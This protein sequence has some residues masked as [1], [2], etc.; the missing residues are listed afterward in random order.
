M[1]LRYE[2]FEVLSCFSL[3]GNVEAAQLKVLQVGL[4]TL[5]T[6]LQETLV[7]NLMLANFPD[8]TTVQVLIEEKKKLAKLTKQK[9]HW[10]SSQKGLGDF[11]ALNVFTSRLNGFKPRQIGERIQLDD[12]IY[13]LQLRAQAVEKR[14]LE[15]GGDH[16]RAQA[17]ILENKV[18]KEQFRILK[19]TI[20]FQE[21]R[22]KLQSFQASSDPDIAEKLKTAQA[23]FNSLNPVKVVL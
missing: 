17:I 2:R 11:T 9:I 4:E 23:E 7:I 20:R 6:G 21:E 15:L 13:S 16:D 12:D 22:L 8:P 14:I 18:L 10:I 19:E 3:R 1:K 5:V